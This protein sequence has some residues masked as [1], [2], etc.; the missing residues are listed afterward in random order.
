MLSDASM[1]SG[2]ATIDNAIFDINGTSVNFTWEELS[3]YCL[4]TTKVY[5]TK[6]V[7]ISF[8]EGDMVNIQCTDLILNNFPVRYDVVGVEKARIVLK[9]LT[10]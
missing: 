7:V 6:D 9:F 2:D 5:P 3:G 8:S 10:T 4:K 1:A